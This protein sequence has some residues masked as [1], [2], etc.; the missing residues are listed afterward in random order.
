MSRAPL[1]QDLGEW[2]IDQALDEPDIVGLFNQVCNRLYA[3]GV[4]LGRARLTWP[5]LHPLF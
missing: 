1:V 5:T 4:P 3:I 2:L